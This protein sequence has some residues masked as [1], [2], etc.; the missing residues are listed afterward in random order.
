MHAAGDVRAGPL[1]TIPPPNGLGVQAEEW[2]V[3]TRSTVSTSF[4]GERELEIPSELVRAGQTPGRR[5]TAGSVMA[6]NKPRVSENAPLLFV[7][8]FLKRSSDSERNSPLNLRRYRGKRRRAGRL[9]IHSSPENPNMSHRDSEE[10]MIRLRSRKIPRGDFAD[11]ELDT[12][13]HLMTSSPGYEPLSSS[14]VHELGKTV[15]SRKKPRQ[16][17]NLRERLYEAA[18]STYG[19]IDPDFMDTA[20]AVRREDVLD[21]QTRVK[22]LRFVPGSGIQ[23]RTRSPRHHQ[24]RRK[25]VDPRKSNAIRTTSFLSSSKNRSA[26]I[27]CN[28]DSAVLMNVLDRL[29]AEK[30]VLDLESEEN[31]LAGRNLRTHRSK[32]TWK[33]KHT[34][35]P[36]LTAESG[37]ISECPPLVFVDFEQ[38]EA[39]YANIFF[40]ERWR[41]F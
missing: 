17:K 34:K 20:A 38:A 12:S 4:D 36:L 2:R 15:R 16:G 11:S 29:P 5:R 23:Q 14:P 10:A 30:W 21:P 37:R 28:S 18:V 26:R 31:T 39:A 7:E 41:V 8:E 19:Y 40:L 9:V 33:Q 6:D 32:T 1:E 25:F 22:P 13:S 35:D 27:A 3:R 24:D